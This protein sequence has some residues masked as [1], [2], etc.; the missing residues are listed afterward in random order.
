M[1]EV[2]PTGQCGRNGNEA[3]A[4]VALEAEAFVRWRH[5]R[6]APSPRKI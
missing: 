2:E 3:L 6:C 1:L 4:G 5:H